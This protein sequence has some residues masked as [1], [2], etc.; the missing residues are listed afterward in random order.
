MRDPEMQI[1]LKAEKAMHQAVKKVI[2]ECKLHG[3][4][5]IVWENGKVV[6]IPASKL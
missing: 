2:A 5:L 3:W 6:K 1:L 4:P